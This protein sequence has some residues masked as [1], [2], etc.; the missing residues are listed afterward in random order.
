[1]WQSLWNLNLF[2]RVKD[3]SQIPGRLLWIFFDM[4]LSLLLQDVA[5]FLVDNQSVPLLLGVAHRT[6]APRLTVRP[7]LVFCHTH[8][9]II[10]LPTHR[11]Y[12][13]Q[14]LQEIC[15]GII[16]NL[17]CH[18]QLCRE[19]LLTENNMYPNPI[20][21]HK[22]I[23]VECRYATIS[24]VHRPWAAIKAVAFLYIFVWASDDELAGSSPAQHTAVWQR[25]H[26]GRLFA[27]PE[28]S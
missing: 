10:T 28:S 5:K 1:M 16:G 21:K 11:Y 20:T 27:A 19:S 7:Y 12:L 26:G 17:A 3:T 23:W 13:L 6:T 22:F 2:V 4:I 8:Q 24:V 18:E 14:C 25:I 15:L 9:L